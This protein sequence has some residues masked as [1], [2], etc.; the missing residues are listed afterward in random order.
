MGMGMATYRLDLEYEG[1]R[2]HG[3]QEQ[4][5]ARSVAGE[6]RAAIEKAGAE[7]VELAGSGRTDSGVH[8]LRQTAHLRLRAARPAEPL[9]LAANDRLPADI[10]ILGVWPAR[11][12]FHARHD[13]I[14]RSYVYQL[15]RRRTA[16]GKRWV[17]WVKRPIDVD[18]L[19][20]GASRIVDRHDFRRLCERPAE[21][22][23]TIV[24]MERVEVV[25]QGDLILI[26]LLA[27][28]FLWKMVRRV[29]GMLARVASGEMRPA[30][31]DDLLDPA[32]GEDLIDPAPYTAPPSGLFLE[33]VLYPGEPG[34]APLAAAVPVT[35]RA[36]PG[37]V[38]F[39][40][41]S[42]SG[43]RLDGRRPR[44]SPRARHRRSTQ[45]P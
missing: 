27:S 21:Q 42:R 24:V 34:L 14:A 37:F 22:P 38:P 15:S 1:T 31:L 8:A 12:G 2:Y 9:R 3:W 39:V 20:E 28:H 40:G 17:W 33:R 10:Q 13:A 35:M 23:S 43:R 18:R 5:N 16:L 32:A 25:E 19:R 7:V 36:E 4:R 44:G 26:R 6:L 41:A 11:T 30:D 45:K 29:V